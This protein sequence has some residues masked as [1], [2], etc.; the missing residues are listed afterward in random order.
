MFKREIIPW[1]WARWA[2][3]SSPELL[4]LTATSPVGM[5]RDSSEHIKVNKIHWN[6]IP[7]LIF[8]WN[9]ILLLYSLPYSLQAS[10]HQKNFEMHKKSNYKIQ[11]N[12]K[13]SLL[14]IIRKSI[15][16]YRKGEESKIKD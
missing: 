4:I 12:K 13:Y 5:L 7:I 10:W 3:S 14:E 15:K 8:N 1:L 6:D 9:L 2:V 16:Q 11:L